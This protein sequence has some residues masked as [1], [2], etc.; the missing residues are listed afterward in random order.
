M[1]HMHCFTRR[2][3]LTT[4]GTL[5]LGL[6]GI[7]HAA[8]SKTTT[9]TD[10]KALVCLFLN[11]GNDS[12]NTV[13]PYDNSEYNSYLIAREGSA[14]RPYGIT[15]LR[16][17]LLPIT[18][19]NISGRQF[20]L[21][22]EML[23]LH[24]KYGAGRC[25]IVANV[26][27]LAYPLTRPEYESGSVELPPQLFS[28]SDQANFWQSGVPSYTTATGWG[29]RIVDNLQRFNATARV[30][31]A[32][33]MVGSNLWQA[34]NTVRSFP[35]DPTNGAQALYSIDDADYGP[36]FTLMLDTPRENLF[37]RELVTTYRRAI[38]GETAIRQALQS[39][40][41]IDALFPRTP[42]AGPDTWHSDLM[43]K[44][45]TTARMIAAA[46]SLNVRRQVFFLSIGGFD[47][48]SSLAG[49]AT[50]LQAISE[51]LARFDTVLNDLGFGNQVISFTASDFGRP[52]RVNGTGSDHGWGGHHFV[53]G[54][55]VAGGQL[56]GTMPNMN[57]AGDSYVGSQGT[58]LPTTSVE[59]YAGSLARWLGVTEA[60]LTD[61]FPRR[62]RFAAELALIR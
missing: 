11:G 47:M 25:A 4:G 41:S 36:A 59:Q 43:N 27:M 2:Q 21:P 8:Q 30:S 18:T 34:A 29:G 13:I 28:H 48:H 3:L 10:Y 23:A 50:A 7:A 24:G 44:L 61:V 15:R 38:V 53:V 49:H 39:T 45:A 52:L 55:A 54:G 51:G 31:S 9:G 33:S 16:Q 32:L 62:G 14:S 60:S 35:I 40:Q 5:A 17:D 42:S 22:K 19:S 6:S 56:A 26:G 12:G 46:N 37:E 58:L 20:A 1:N 57:L